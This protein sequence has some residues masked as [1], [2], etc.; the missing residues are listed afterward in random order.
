VTQC[1]E[2]STSISM[3]RDRSWLLKLLVAERMARE[4]ANRRVFAMDESARLSGE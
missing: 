3:F 4:V 2:Y 1:S